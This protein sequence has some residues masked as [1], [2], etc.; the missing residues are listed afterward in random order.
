MRRSPGEGDLLNPGGQ[1]P[2]ISSLRGA[3]PVRLPWPIAAPVRPAAPTAPTPSDLSSPPR[4]CPQRG[5]DRPSSRARDPATTSLQG[6]HTEEGA[7]LPTAG[8]QGATAR[9]V[10]GGLGVM[11]SP[12]T[13][14][15]RLPGSERPPGA[16][17][18]AARLPPTSAPAY[19]AVPMT[20]DAGP[21]LRSDLC[22]TSAPLRG[23]APPAAPPSP[24]SGGAAVW[25]RW[26]RRARPQTA[27]GRAL[28][29]RALDSSGS[30]GPRKG[31]RSPWSGNTGNTQVLLGACYR[32]VC[33]P[34][35]AL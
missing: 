27:V 30:R 21:A 5:Q 32:P 24:G 6:T 12:A 23:S 18:Q 33:H 2:H 3:G 35:E 8:P 4:C 26:R 7:E 19:A 28:R 15:A 34:E 9:T 16:A 11:W 22:R 13:P 25:R 31:I 29:V 10:R 20:T 1:E 17:V 14:A